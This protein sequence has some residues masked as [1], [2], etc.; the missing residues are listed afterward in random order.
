MHD[1]FKSVGGDK[2]LAKMHDVLKS[3][4]GDKNLAKMHDVLKS[5]AKIVQKNETA[6][7]AISEM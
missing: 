3:V 7:K 1:V 2:N 5:G 4:G 6:K